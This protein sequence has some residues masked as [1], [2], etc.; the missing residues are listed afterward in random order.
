MGGETTGW[1]RGMLL[2]MKS[3]DCKGT[4]WSNGV[5]VHGKKLHRLLAWFV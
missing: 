3:C 4:V 1:T 5:Y 2:R